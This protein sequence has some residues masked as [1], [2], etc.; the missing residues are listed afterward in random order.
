MAKK[1]EWVQIA[2]KN[3]KIP[4]DAS[5]M[6][7]Y[8]ET[9]ET[10]NN[11]YIDEVIGAV[12]GTTIIGAEPSTKP[13]DSVKA[14]AGDANLDG[15]VDIADAVAVASYVGDSK[16]N[17]LESQGLINADVQGDGN[18]VNANDA[19][20]IQQYLA[21]II[22]KLENQNPLP[23]ITTTTTA[24]TTAVTQT[25]PANPTKTRKKSN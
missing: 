13:S 12:G 1:G 18:G 23:V 14:L 20:M 11:F 17:A 2:N 5:N 6:Q 21:G 22:G 15:I 7:I 8:I 25:N 24:T 9:A 3:Y 4:A 16:L 19:L 10:T